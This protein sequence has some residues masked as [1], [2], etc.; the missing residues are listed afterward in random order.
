MWG[1]LLSGTAGRCLTLDLGSGYGLGRGIEP[2]L[3]CLLGLEPA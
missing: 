3:G 1:G 2:V